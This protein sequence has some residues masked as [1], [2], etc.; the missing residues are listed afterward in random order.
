MSVTK[1]TPARTVTT[2][3]G[4]VLPATVNQRTDLN[5]LPIAAGVYLCLNEGRTASDTVLNV[6]DAMRD[7]NAVVSLY[8]DS[9]GMEARVIWPDS[10]SLTTDNHIVCRGYC[11]LRKEFR[12]FRLVAWCRVIRS[13]RPTMRSQQPASRSIGPGQVQC[14]FHPPNESTKET[15][16]WEHPR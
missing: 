9:G 15:K 4:Y 2:L 13:V 6:F 1:S 8:V 7:S 16:E 10:I 14:L 11:T 5:A 12:S 3:G